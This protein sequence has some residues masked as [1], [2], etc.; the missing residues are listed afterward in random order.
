MTTLDR[1]TA[2][3]I[4]QDSVAAL[5]AVAE[6]YGLAVEHRGGAIA[7]TYVELKFQFSRVAES[8][9]VLSREATDFSRYASMYG[10]RPEDLGATFTCNGTAYR[11]SG[12][13]PRKSRMPVLATRVSDGRSFKF[14]VDA[15]RR[16]VPVTEESKG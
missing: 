2:R 1:N 8:G 5:K 16:S 9:Q 4:A 11:I 15:V 12:L 3:L 13:S 7:S 10:L 6:K 14:T